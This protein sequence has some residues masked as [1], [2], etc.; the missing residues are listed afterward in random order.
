MEGNFQQPHSD[1]QTLVAPEPTSAFEKYVIESFSR[2]DESFKKLDS[3]IDDVIE[4]QQFMMDQM[5]THDELDEKLDEF[6]ANLKAEITSDLKTHTT[7][8]CGKINDNVTA[9]I[10]KCDGRTDDVIVTLERKKVI[11]SSESGGMLRTSPFAA[12]F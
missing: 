9:L 1:Q 7:I 8:E 11:S 10:K 3:K 12:T 2:T 4:N 6:G 5:V